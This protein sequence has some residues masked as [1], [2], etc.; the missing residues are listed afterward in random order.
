MTAP[1]NAGIAVDPRG[2]VFI[3]YRQADGTPYAVD[4][5][6]LLRAA[7]LPVWHD[8]TDLPPGDTMQRLE[9]ALRD[10]LSGAVLIITPDV[11]N[12]AAVKTMEAPRLVDLSEHTDFALWVANAI[13]QDDKVDYNAPD[14]LLGFSTPR[15]KGVLQE[16]PDSEQGLRRI[17]DKML[18]NRLERAATSIRDAG[19]V[20]TM[21]VQTRGTPGAFEQRS[22]ILQVRLMPVSGRPPSAEGLDYLKR[23]LSSLYEGV[24]T[25]AVDKVTV[26]GG[27]H[28]S[29][30]L[31]I[32]ATLPT[33]MIGR[34]SVIDRGEEWVGPT[35]AAMPAEPR[36]VQETVQNGSAG[37]SKV[38]VY[39]DL[40]P[41]GRDEPFL[42]HLAAH[43]TEYAAAVHV[44][45][46]TPDRNWTPQDTEEVVAEAAD[47]IRALHSRH[48][49]AEVHL[50][51]HTPWSFSFLLGRLLNT[52]KVVTYELDD[53]NQYLA[54]LRLRDTSVGGSIEE[55]LLTQSNGDEK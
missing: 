53:A 31:A 15:L 35:L 39:L 54:C 34:A 3:S 28:L 27:A 33:T 12:S 2:P 45:S 30:A 44:R 13:T 41:H 10:G 17:V 55:V 7:G 19:G 21:R 24:S 22:E 16:S 6:W 40:I 14:V 26:S 18:R 50:F 36:L 42:S 47:R 5:A 29:V 8:Q 51:L 46:V 25:A 23:S 48:S 49:G 20:L 37:N 9:E 1:T 38:A 4:L 11:V 52:V 32:G 43:G